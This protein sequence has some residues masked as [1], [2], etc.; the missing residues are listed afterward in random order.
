[1]AFAFLAFGVWL[2]LARLG[3]LSLR[4]ALFVPISMLIWITHTFG[5]VMLGVMAFSAEFVIQHD[6]ANNLLAAGCSSALPCLALAPPPLHPLPWRT[7][8]APAQTGG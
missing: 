7:G 2:R 3:R 8:P 6:R 5:W 4:A 1:M